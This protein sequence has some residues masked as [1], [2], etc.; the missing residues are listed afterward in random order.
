MSKPTDPVLTAEELEWFGAP[1]A[2]PVQVEAEPAE[3][4]EEDPE[5]PAPNPAEVLD[6]PGWKEIRC[7]RC[8]HSFG[9]RPAEHSISVATCPKV[10]DHGADCDDCGHPI[11]VTSEGPSCPNAGSHGQSLA[12]VAEKPKRKRRT[13]AEMEA[14][15]A[16]IPSGNEPAEETPPTPAEI[17]SGKVEPAPYAA[18]EPDPFHPEN[19]FV[20]AQVYTDDHAP[21]NIA[22]HLKDCGMEPRPARVVLF[23]SN[24]LA[25]PAPAFELDSVQIF[26]GYALLHGRLGEEETPVVVPVAAAWAR[27]LEPGKAYAVD[28]LVRDDG[29]RV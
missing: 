5:L 27:T 25:L 3:D 24:A 6:G 28:S 9:K 13:K 4:A 23:T 26:A 17:P 15:R 29:S 22:Q 10:N 1:P 16:E 8:D 18:N 14:A 12:P 20:R 19:P 11:A 21:E 7:S 2:A